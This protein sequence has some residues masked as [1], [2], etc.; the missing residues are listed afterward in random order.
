MRTACLHISLLLA[1]LCAPALHAADLVIG[2]ATEQSSLDPLFARSGTNYSTSGQIFDRLVHNDPNNQLQPALAVSWRAIDATTWEIKLRDKVKFHDGSDFTADDVIFSFERA[3]NVPNSPASFAGSVASIVNMRALDRLTVQLKTSQPVPSLIEQVGRAFILSKKAANGL[4]TTDFNSGKGMIGTGP[5]KFVEWRPAQHLKL[6]RNGA[7]WGATPD[8]ENV[9]LKYI[10]KDV[11]RISALLAGDVDMIDEVSPDGAKQLKSNEKVRVF[12]IGS[13]RLIYLSVDSDR[14]QSPFITDAAGKPLDRNPLKDVR[15][16]RALSLMI[17]R[18]LFVERLLDGSGEP[19]G[20]IVPQGIGGYDASLAPP[21][22]DVALAKKLLAEAGWP[23]GFGITLHTSNDRFA[24]DSDIVQAIG[25][26]LSRG[27]IKINNVVALPYNVYA[28]AATRREYSVFLFG[29]GTTTPDS[30]IGLSNVF[31]TFDK[32]A[33][34]GALNRSRYSNAQFDAVLK[35]ALSEFDEPKRLAGLKEATRVAF[36]DVAV[37][38]LYWPTVH[39]ATRKGIA[40]KPRRGEETLA[41][42]ASLVK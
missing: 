9:T 23:G 35:R 31:A 28:S 21:R 16:R 32:E 29:W 39:W 7:Y 27:G 26:M 33:G 4:T 1:A 13:T 40:Y 42:E 34:L 38:P 37:I 19:A 12:S 41:Q 30:S 24:R 15:V 18:K 8:F 25:Q 14:D 10:A 6:V 22:Q 3:R 11:A 2:R 20:Q 5:Y 17:D 36:N